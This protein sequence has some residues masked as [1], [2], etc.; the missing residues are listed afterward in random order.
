M[1]TPSLT[2]PWYA[3]CANSCARPRSSSPLRCRARRASRDL[4]KTTAQLR[5]PLELCYHSL[6]ACGMGNIADGM[7]L[8]VLRKLACFGIHLVK[9]DIRQDG[10]RHGQ[11]F[12]S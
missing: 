6:H 10:E 11:V 12:S 7:L 5:E 1:I 4:V 9:L 3:S 2:A 8:D